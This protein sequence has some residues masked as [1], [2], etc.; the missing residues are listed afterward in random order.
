MTVCLR[1]DYLNWESNTLATKAKK[2]A[3][4]QTASSTKVTRISATD[5]AAAPKKDAVVKKSAKKQAPAAKPD[6]KT[7]KLKSG[8]GGFIGYF[9]GAWY[10]LRQVKWPS[11]KATWGLTGAMLAF[12]A[13]F[14]VVILLLDALFQ[15]LFKLML[16]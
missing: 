11:R 16:G 3:E 10:E 5:T 2:P 14:G 1:A 6:K 8:F 12:T 13:F 4:K 15:Y 9:K 7:N